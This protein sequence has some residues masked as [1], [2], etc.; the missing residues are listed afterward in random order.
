MQT[1][2]TAAQAAL[3]AI[4]LSSCADAPVAGKAETAQPTKTA[5]ASAPEV[6]P[7]VLPDT[8][9]RTVPDPVS[10]RTYQIFVNLPQSYKDSPER[11]YPVLYVTDANYAFPLLNGIVRAVRDKETGLEDFI[12]VGLSYAV[13]DD[14]VVSRNRDY[15]PT[16]AGSKAGNARGDI[17]GGA[18]AYRRYL[19]TQVLP[20]V[21]STYRADATRR[22]FLGHSYGAL[23]GAHTLFASP[24]MFSSYILGSPSFW[25]DRGHMFRVEE[26]YAAAHK[27]LPAKVFMYIGGFETLRPGDPRYNDE[28]DMVGDMKRFEQALKARNY[29]SLTIAS[30]V[31]D[32][33]GHR[34]VV[35]SG[36]T[37]A[38]KTV[39]P[40]R[41][42]S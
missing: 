30:H 42:Q 18:E 28:D 19:E 9:V 15:T 4:V 25:Y 31:F 11:R 34:S 23:L 24:G 38:L 41:R 8:E 5:E 32:Q 3:S 17:H 29:P 1:M 14:P 20:L 10:G 16:K 27:D 13:G 6:Q 2:K 40:P 33:E 12:L 26:Q 36:F 22:I 7:Y 39:L 21:D 35:P 37:R